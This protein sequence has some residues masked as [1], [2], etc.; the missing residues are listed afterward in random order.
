MK[1]YVSLLLAVI[2]VLSMTACSSTATEPETSVYKADVQEYITE[3]LDDTAEISIFE[4]KSSDLNGDKLTVV[5]VAMYSGEAGEQ[6]GEFTLTYVKN[7]KTWELD[8]CRVNLDDESNSDKIPDNTEATTVPTT[9]ATEPAATA[10]VTEIS[11]NWKDFT[12]SMGGAVYQLPAH[13]QNF[14]ANGWKLDGT[15][16]D[17][18]EDDMVAGYSRVYIY[19]TNGAV[20]FDAEI[21][22]LSGHARAV[23]D[24]DIGAITIQ[25]N[26]N[27]DLKLSS[28]IGCLSTVEDIQKAYGTPS[29]M[30]T[31]TDYSSL[32][33]EVDT[34][35]SMRFYI[36]N[37]K[38]TY[39]EI[40][41][42][43]FVASERDVTVAKEERP[44]YLDTYVAPTE[45]GSDI[46]STRFMLDGVVYQLPC[47]L[48][49]FTDN[50]WTIKSDS[51]GT[52]GAWNDEYGVTIV[53][54][55]YRV[56]LTM[57]NLSDYETYTKNCAVSAVSFEGNYFKGAPKDIVQLPGGTNL[58]STV[59]EVQDL[60]KDFSRYDGTYS[61]S[62]SYD[63]K[64]YTE[65]VK[66]S[67][68][69]D[70]NYGSIEVKNENWNY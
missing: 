67:F 19:L 4:K 3:I 43:N 48:D 23:K 7:G 21:I 46:N 69:K 51:I 14:V 9:E 10:G 17:I 45:L 39:N 38:T 63:S 56:Y 28:G 66:Y 16:S 68:W 55:D 18:T 61:T 1:K 27:L 50:G 70:N 41:L 47:P 20:Y 49:A 2:L 30:N 33:Y 40:T 25:A 13:Y 35:I 22:N 8:K 60:Y 32:K 59:E 37:S 58:W 12:F 34:Y 65:K 44:A 36:Y 15:R 31:S 24:C 5:C 29:D 64:D 42:R 54:G 11:D 52:L 26:D 57:I 6:K 53:K 62:F